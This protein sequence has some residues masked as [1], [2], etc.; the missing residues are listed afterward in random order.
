ML[1]QQVQIVRI[2]LGARIARLAE[3][4]RSRDLGASAIELA[5]ITA[6][7]VGLAALVLG[8]V[9]PIVTNRS[10]EINTNNGKIP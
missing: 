2:I 3:A 9:I 10:N 6:V 5:I 7:L 8:I 1:I 4:R